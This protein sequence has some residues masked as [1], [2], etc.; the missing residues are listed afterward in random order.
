MSYIYFKI[1][2]FIGSCTGIPMLHRCQ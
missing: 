1:V 2:Q